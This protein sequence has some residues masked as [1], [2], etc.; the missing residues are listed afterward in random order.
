[1]LLNVSKFITI[2]EVEYSY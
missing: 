1:M 2:F